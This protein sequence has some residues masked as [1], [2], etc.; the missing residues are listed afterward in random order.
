MKHLPR[1]ARRALQW[2]PLLF[3]SGALAGPVEVGYTVSGGPK[4][5]TLDFWV[6]NKLG[7]TGAAD[8]R[9]FVVGLKLPPGSVIVAPEGFEVERYV[10]FFHGW[11]PGGSSTRYNFAWSAS[12]AEFLPAQTV[13]GFLV[14]LDQAEPP[15]SV[16][17]FVL[18]RSDSRAEFR[19]NGHFGTRLEPGFE[20]LAVASVPEPGTYGLLG[21]GL[22]GVALVGQ[23]RRRRGVSVDAT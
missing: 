8:M 22:A 17:W 14:H 18:A 10:E 4:Q 13:S 21:V 9:I 7:P 15:E 1:C 20:G 23:Y 2:L 6:Q 5:W 16:P 3:L 19:G 12:T 11:S